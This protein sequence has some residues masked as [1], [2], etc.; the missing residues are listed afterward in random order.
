[1]QVRST[2]F[3]EVLLLKSKIHKDHRG[4][5]SEQY[6]RKNFNKEIGIEIDFFKII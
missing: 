4:S 6:Q 1:M 2:L 3:K 5:F